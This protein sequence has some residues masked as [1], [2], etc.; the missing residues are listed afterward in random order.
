MKIINNK[1]AETVWYLLAI[2]LGVMLIVA[3]VY[4]LFVTNQ[5]NWRFFIDAP[6]NYTDK[7]KL[8][9]LEDYTEDDL[10]VLNC[11]P[12]AELALN[13]DKNYFYFKIGGEWT[14]VYLD[15]DDY[16][17]FVDIDKSF[18]IDWK[19]DVEIGWVE[20]GVIKIYEDFLYGK[21]EVMWDY[22]D[23]FPS[24]AKLKALHNSFQL[25]GGRVWCYEEFYEERCEDVENY[26]VEI[27][28]V[29]NNEIFYDDLVTGLY[30]E[31]DIIYF[32]EGTMFGDP[33]VG[34]IGVYT[35]GYEFIKINDNFLSLTSKDY[36]AYAKEG[37]PEM[38]ILKSL[39]KSVVLES[40][41]ICKKNG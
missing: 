21:S 11:K 18:I 7:D 40:G 39:D 2:I 10:K 20:D 8:L 28:S 12:V 38:K 17:I 31:D 14:N 30:L 35:D 36:V 33:K 25:S 3:I 37:L 34:Y 41:A 15:E 23:D 22:P 5:K 29:L 9:G 26:E 6:V 24:V 13:Q 16:K 32:D 4:F 19:G 27:G 1:K